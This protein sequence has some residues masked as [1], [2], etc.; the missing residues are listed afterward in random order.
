MLWTFAR[1]PRM[2][3]L[4]RSLLLGSILSVAVVAACSSTQPAGPSDASV[5]DD[6]D[7][8]PKNLPSTCPAT[9]PSFKNDVEPIF[10]TKCWTCHADGG[11]EAAQDDLGSYD[12]IFRLRGDE[13]SQIYSCRMPNVGAP[14]LTQDERLTMMSWFVCGAPN[15]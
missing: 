9:V 14:P 6:V 15:N 12:A 11:V 4:V 3:R 7:T 10:A 2:L 8:C 13:L 1:P 5:A